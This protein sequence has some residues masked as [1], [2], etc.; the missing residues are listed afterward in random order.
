MKTENPQYVAYYDKIQEQRFGCATPGTASQINTIS[1]L[2]PNT[3]NE[4]TDSPLAI[5]DRKRSA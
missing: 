5:A 1:D 2:S 3:G 4:T